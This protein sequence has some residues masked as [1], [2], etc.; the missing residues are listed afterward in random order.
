V[1]EELEQEEARLAAVFQRKA[2]DFE[3]LQ[4]EIAGRDNGR[5]PRFL[6]KDRR[7][8]ISGKDRDADRDHVLSALQQLLQN[9][10][11]YAALYNDTMN[12]LTEAEKAT[13]IA[14]EKALERQRVAEE[15]LAE[16]RESAL[17]LEDGQRVYRDSNGV[18]RFEDGSAA[19]DTG[20]SV[21]HWHPGM[22]GYE[23]FVA[24][25]DAAEAE[26]ATVNEIMLYQVEVLGDAR[27][28]LSD[29]DSP[30]DADELRDIQTSIQAEMPES[31]RQQMPSEPMA[32]VAH[33]P[34]V[35]PAIPEL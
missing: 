10:P 23:D 17:T 24:H 2:Q 32:E 21:E 13:E 19:S 33:R 27:D 20:A 16:L 6:N 29:E 14:L 15:A 11:E 22:P 26:A 9:D 7:D 1:F 12:A 30:P 8:G 4:N 28:R 31:V 5:A 18:F 35:A 25:R 3:D 34:A